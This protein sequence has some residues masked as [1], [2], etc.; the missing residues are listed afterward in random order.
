VLDAVTQLHELKLGHGDI[1]P[2]QFLITADGDIK[3][4][5]FG[6]AGEFSRKMVG[7]DSLVDCPIYQEP[8]AISAKNECLKKTIQAEKKRN[9]R[10]K[11]L[12]D[13]GHARDEAKST[14]LQEE[15]NPEY[16]INVEKG[17][18]YSAAG[19]LYK[20]FFNEDPWA[21]NIINKTGAPG[22]WTA[23]ENQI[24][25]RRGKPQYR[26]FA[27]AARTSNRDYWDKQ[28][29]AAN[30][31]IRSGMA[32]QNG[33]ASTKGMAQ[34]EFFK[35]NPSDETYCK[36]ALVELVDNNRKLQSNS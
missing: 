7:R 1:K 26:R 24:S 4:A 34:R 12:R 2:A 13:N 17:D 35:L 10:V 3:L 14:S 21:H 31:T 15:P 33:R 22:E 11:E 18:Y 36:K 25:L 20:I 29:R 27:S 28:V 32:S 23:I 30:S 6:T 5:D 8:D 16:S 19:S 9:A